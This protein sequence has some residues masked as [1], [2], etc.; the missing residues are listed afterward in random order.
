MFKQHYMRRLP[1]KTKGNLEDQNLN[2]NF[3]N[4]YVLLYRNYKTHTLMFS[5]S[6]ISIQSFSP[7]VEDKGDTYHKRHKCISVIIF[8]YAVTD[9]IFKH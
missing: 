9:F 6:D 1:T 8:E 4:L 7:K 5:Y 2:P 3:T